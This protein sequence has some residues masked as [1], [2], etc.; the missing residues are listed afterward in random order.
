MDHTLPQW[1]YA[2]DCNHVFPMDNLSKSLT[3][4]DNWF[5]HADKSEVM[6]INNNRTLYRRLNGKQSSKE[7]T[8]NL[9]NKTKNTI[10]SIYGIDFENLDFNT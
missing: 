7:I 3:I 8:E 4:I 9:S 2:R 6:K 10:K 5:D 1:S